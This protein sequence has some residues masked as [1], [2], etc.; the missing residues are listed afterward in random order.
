[1]NNWNMHANINL[2]ALTWQEDVQNNS[3][4]L[5]GT[6]QKWC[7]RETEMLVKKLITSSA[8]L[9]EESSHIR[10]ISYW[11]PRPSPPV[12]S[13][14][15]LCCPTTHP[16]AFPTYW[17][18]L[19]QLSWVIFFASV[20]PSASTCTFLRALAKV[21]TQLYM[22]L[23]SAISILSLSY[24]PRTFTKVELYCSHSKSLKFSAVTKT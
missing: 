10:G 21:I 11:R 14:T 16:P 22:C 3:L 7:G 1:M 8:S 23:Y 5:D 4:W 15:L 18:H 2:Q 19:K 17:E 6:S 12:P 13:F 20:L 24:Y 9:L